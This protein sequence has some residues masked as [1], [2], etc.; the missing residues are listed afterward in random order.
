MYV[1]TYRFNETHRQT[2]RLKESHKSKEVVAY[3]I[4]PIWYWTLDIIV[5]F[6]FVVNGRETLLNV[7]KPH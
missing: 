2:H 4:K 5:L 6:R 1:S 3:G 7:Q